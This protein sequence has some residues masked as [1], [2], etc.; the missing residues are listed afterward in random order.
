MQPDTAP[1]TTPGRSVP[2]YAQDSGVLTLS[3]RSA[4]GVYADLS[5]AVARELLLAGIPGATIARYAVIPDER[6]QIEA[7]LCAWADGG[8]GADRHDRRHGP[9]PPRR[10]PRRDPGRADLPGA[11][12][13]RSDARRQPGRRPRWRCSRGR[14]PAC[15]GAR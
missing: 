6:A 10:D 3:D 13:R 4:A 1:L 11:G 7:T 12:H 8:A 5:G 2:E 14:W 15:A 9:G